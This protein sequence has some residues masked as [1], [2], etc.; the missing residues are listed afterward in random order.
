MG[1]GHES[2]V[3]GRGRRAGGP[4]VVLVG[5]GGANVNPPSLAGTSRRRRIIGF[6]MPAK[7]IGID[8]S[9]FKKQVTFDL[10]LESPW[11]RSLA[12]GYV[13]LEVQERG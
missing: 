5:G 8:K 3:S 12:Q 6:E 13:G 4:L 2:G 10:A 1:R 11:V 9:C 7:L